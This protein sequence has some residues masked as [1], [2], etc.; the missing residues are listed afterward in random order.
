M[1]RRMIIL[2]GGITNP[3]PAK[4]A[5]N[6][7]RYKPQ[8]VV[9]ILDENNRGKASR[10]LFGLGGMI[11][12][13]ASL[14]QAP[15]ANTVVVGIAPTGGKL[16][17]EMKATIL[18]AIRRKLTI[19]SG[20]HEFLSSDAE[21]AQAARQHGARLV[22][23]RKNEERD[24]AHRQGLREQCLRI[25]TVGHD[26]N[27]GKMVVSLELSLA[28]QK[29]GHDA[30]FVATGQTGIL[31]E[32]D[33][34]PIDAV[35]SDFVNGAAEKLVLANQ[36]HSILLIEGQ[37]S[38][39]HPRYSAVTLGLLHGCV[40][41]GLI[42]CYEMGREF[43]AGMDTCKIPPLSTLKQLYETMANLMHP[44]RVI[45]VAVNGRKYSDTEVAQ[46]C[47]KVRRE[48]GLPVCDVLRHGSNDLV[49]AIL[50]LKKQLGKS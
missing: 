16:P 31:I 9:A 20:L 34:C 19:V 22:D 49:K 33:G 32:G 35:V 43:V 42:L 17:R 10:E 14:D 37:G 29:A 23:V 48:M 40:P 45:G 4:T 11:P 28:L 26:C 47:E 36:Q 30:K 41:D 27:V 25:H 3:G 2:T 18:E 6:L 13:V 5:V 1:T 44:C 8:E 15:E 12:V 46:E 7:L 50:E 38:L 21:I 24:V 39:A